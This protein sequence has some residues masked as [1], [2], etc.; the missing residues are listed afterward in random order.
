MKRQTRNQHQE[1]EE[2]E[3]EF[4]TGSEEENEE[5]EEENE[6]REDSEEKEK[7]RE[8]EQEESQQPTNTSESESD[9]TDG[10]KGSKRTP[11]TTRGKNWTWNNNYLLIK[12]VYQH[13][14]AWDKVLTSLH[15]LHVATHI[16]N[17]NNLR[18]HFNTLRGQRSVLNKPYKPKPFHAPKNTLTRQELRQQENKY[19]EMVV[20]ERKQ[21]KKAKRMMK[22]IDERE[23]LVGTN[24]RMSAEEAK[25]NIA[26]QKDERRAIRDHRLAEAEKEALEE[27]EFRVAMTQ[28]L[29]HIN[30]LLPICLNTEKMLLTYLRLKVAQLQQEGVVERLEEEGQVEQEDDIPAEQQEEDMLEEL[31][32]AAE[33]PAK[34]RRQ[35]HT[36]RKRRGI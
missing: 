35:T 32:V 19:T 31:Q 15:S 36:K 28:T 5:S 4:G 24:K 9:S 14:K 11:R 30:K 1:R 2:E 6:E 21:R 10:S 18:I 25:A 34:Q 12:S 33:P 22:V 8:T 23:V 16:H 17:K 20:K 29:S 26:Q 13:G 3:Q 7:E 27:R